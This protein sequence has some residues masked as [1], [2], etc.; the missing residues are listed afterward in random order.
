[1]KINKLKMIISTVII[2]LPTVF[3]LI[4]SKQLSQTIAIHWGLD[5][6]PDQYASTLWVVVLFPALI[7]ILQWICVFITNKTNQNIK[8]SKKV[9]ELIYWICPAISIFSSGVIYSAGLGLKPDML[10]L[11]CC[12]FGI[13][14]IIIGNYMPKCL[15]N[16]TVG[17]KIKWTLANEENWNATHRFTGRVW[18][19]SGI[20]LFLIAFLQGNIRYYCITTV[21]IVAIMSP[22]VYSYIYYRK[23]L[24][25]GALTKDDFKYQCSSKRAAIVGTIVTVIILATVLFIMFTGNVKIGFYDDKLEIDATYWEDT[26]LNFSDISD[27]E[28]INSIEKAERL[29]GFASGRLMLGWFNSQELENHT[30]YMYISCKSCVLI[31]TKEGKKLVINRPDES[32]TWALY[33]DLLLRLDHLK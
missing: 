30:R 5:G 23:Q 12:F 29:N 7:A 25:G 3:G 15:Q 28:Y 19:F 4:F 33:E 6:N 27:V 8:Q 2:F 1:M 14:F 10:F 24:S 21:M 26:F 22:L 32:Q 20:V 11:M 16:S 17:I 9:L 31:T 18:F 13:L